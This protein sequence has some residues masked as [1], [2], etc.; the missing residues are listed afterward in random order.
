[1]KASKIMRSKRASGLVILLFFATKIVCT[2][3]EDTNPVGISI[4][5]PPILDCWLTIR[6]IKGCSEQLHDL[7]K[8]NITKVLPQCCRAVTGM[9]DY[10]MKLVFSSSFTLDFGKVVKKLCT[11]LGYGKPPSPFIRL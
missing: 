6:K 9:S 2:L 10:C 4:P 7:F 3:A 8:H 1:M 5:K 11:L